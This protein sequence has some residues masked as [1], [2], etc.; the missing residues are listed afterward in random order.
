MQT[1]QIKTYEPAFTALLDRVQLSPNIFMLDFEA[2][3]RTAIECAPWIP[4]SE[5]NIAFL[6]SRNQFFVL[7]EVI[8]CRICISL[9]KSSD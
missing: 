9:T 3:E 2:G 5:V 4:T 7:L 1:I 6:T 8:A